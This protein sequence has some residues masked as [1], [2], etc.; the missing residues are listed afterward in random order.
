MVYDAVISFL[1][2]LDDGSMDQFVVLLATNLKQKGFNLW[3]K[4]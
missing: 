2:I 3:F 1:S 4:F